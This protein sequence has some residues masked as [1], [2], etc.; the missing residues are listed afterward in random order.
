[1]EQKSEKSSVFYHFSA[2]FNIKV[3]FKGQE[4]EKTKNICVD[5]CQKDD[6]IDS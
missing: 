3:L 2:F 5:I 1:M 4:K 6:I